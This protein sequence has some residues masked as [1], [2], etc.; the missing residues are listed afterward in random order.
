MLQH[1]TVNDRVVHFEFCRNM[2]NCI[3]EDE[4]FLSEIFSSNKATFHLSGKV[5]R[6]NI[7]VWGGENP[8]TVVEHSRDSPK[9]NVFCAVSCDKVYGPFFFGKKT[10]NII[11]YCDMLELWLMPQLLEDKPNAVFQHDGEPP[12]IHSEV[13][14]FL[15]RQL[16]ERWIDRGESTS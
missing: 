7:L 11:I 8:H 5:N 13:T 6:H 2:M 1:V 4:T 15:N 10:V 12:H 3:A 14:T 16:P 9:I